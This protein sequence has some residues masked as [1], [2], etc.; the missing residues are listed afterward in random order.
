M[1]NKFYW[2]F[3]TNKRLLLL[4][5]VKNPNINLNLRRNHHKWLTCIPDVWCVKSW[6]QQIVEEPDMMGVASI[7][8]GWMGEPWKSILE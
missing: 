7:V 3:V 8:M 6:F 1:L 4:L 2:E 5:E